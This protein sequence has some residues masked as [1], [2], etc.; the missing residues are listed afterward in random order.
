MPSEVAQLFAAL[1][2]SAEAHR[3]ALHGIE[4]AL[5]ALSRSRVWKRIKPDSSSPSARS[6]PLDLV[7]LPSQTPGAVLDRALV[8]D[9]SRS[10]TGTEETE[11]QTDLFQDTNAESGQISTTTTT[12]ENQTLETR[13]SPTPPSPL[14]GK[15]WRALLPWEAGAPDRKAV[16]KGRDGLYRG[17]CEAWDKAADQAGAIARQHDKPVLEWIP[18]PHPLSLSKRLGVLN[19]IAK[20]YRYESPEDFVRKFETLLDCLTQDSWW[21]SSIRRTKPPHILDVLGTFALFQT[22]R[23]SAKNVHSRVEFEI[24]DVRHDNKRNNDGTIVDECPEPD[25]SQYSAKESEA[26]E[27]ATRHW[28][29]NKD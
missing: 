26:R 14:L 5:G 23:A 11:N 28:F 13:P 10:R 21:H 16:A 7:R 6:S 19:K 3:I 22:A 24:E 18:A 17:L 29:A 2:L 8:L 20:V 27:A 15:R 4:E 25:L 12:A 9:R 1:Q